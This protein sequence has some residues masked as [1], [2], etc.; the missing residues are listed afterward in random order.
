MRME[1]SAWGVKLGSA[2][3]EIAICRRNAIFG[4]PRGDS[5][6]FEAR[7]SQIVEPAIIESRCNGHGGP[8]K[9]ATKKQKRK[10]AGTSK[11]TGTKPKPKPKP[12][13]KKK[14]SRGK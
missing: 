8:G 5:C 1:W 11:G 2:S 9:M 4:T 12:K 3:Q 13:P 6:L 14:T 10:T 7:A